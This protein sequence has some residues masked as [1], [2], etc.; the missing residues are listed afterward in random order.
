LFVFRGTA[1]NNSHMP[2]MGC[3]VQGLR[4]VQYAQNSAGTEPAPM[5]DVVYYVNVSTCIYHIH[6]F[7]YEVPAG[8]CVFFF[9]FSFFCFFE[10]GFL[11]SPGCPRTHFA[12]QA[13]LELRNS[14]A[15]ASQMLGLQACTTTAWLGVFLKYVICDI[16]ACMCC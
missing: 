6:V 11:C 7:T 14:P 13:G 5:N 9:F 15:S 3:A 1:I 10:T 4:F 8:V 12:D 2:S 16:C